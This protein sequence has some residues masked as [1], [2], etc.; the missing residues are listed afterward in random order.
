MVSEYRVSLGRL[1]GGEE[2]GPGGLCWFGDGK[3]AS[4]AGRWYDVTGSADAWVHHCEF[5]LWV[6]PGQLGKF[7]G[8]R[9]KGAAR[10]SGKGA[11]PP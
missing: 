8:K 3:V 9:Q 1:F 10:S 11:M 4:D 6:S 7:E 2:K 5:H